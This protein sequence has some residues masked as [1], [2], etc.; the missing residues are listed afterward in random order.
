MLM[1]VSLMLALLLF[2]ISVKSFR[3][4]PCIIES[5]SPRD[6]TFDQSL[7]INPTLST[8]FQD[9]TSGT[10]ITYTIAN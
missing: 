1:K 9:L 6:Q 4:A 3:E 5:I 2:P 7:D 10:T 8:G